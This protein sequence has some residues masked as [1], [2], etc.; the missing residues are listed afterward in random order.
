[1]GKPANA[2]ERHKP[3][4]IDLSVAQ[5]AMDSRFEQV[6]QRR[7]QDVAS[8]LSLTGMA[9]C[10][11]GAGR[12]GYSHEGPVPKWFGRDCIEAHCPLRKAA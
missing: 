10:K 11:C 9:L 8:G 2:R 6:R 4:S 1:M 7:A 3:Q 5:S 12:I